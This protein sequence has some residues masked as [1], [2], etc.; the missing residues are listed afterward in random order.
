MDLIEVCNLEYN[1]LK[2]LIF[3]AFSLLLTFTFWHYKVDKAS[4]LD[5]AIEY[6]KTLQLQ[7][8]V[9]ILFFFSDK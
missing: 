1:Q 8:Q 5:E 9:N 6:L 3:S 4:M 7:V 2:I